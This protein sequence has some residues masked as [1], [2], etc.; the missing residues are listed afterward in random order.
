MTEEYIINVPGRIKRR[1]G[2][3]VA[4]ESQ[5]GFGKA[6][7]PDGSIL[8]VA[9]DAPPLRVLPGGKLWGMEGVLGARGAM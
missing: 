1:E 2:V 7:L 5:F 8:Y 4:R 3:I 6:T 9:P